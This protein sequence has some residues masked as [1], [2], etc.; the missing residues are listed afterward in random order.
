MFQVK[1]VGHKEIY[2]LCH[3]KCFYEI[4]GLFRIGGG[5]G[6]RYNVYNVLTESTRTK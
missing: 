6:N 5:G 1:V 2:V 4:N 3:V